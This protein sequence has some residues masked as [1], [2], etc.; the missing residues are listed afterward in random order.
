MM[1]DSILPS[2]LPHFSLDGSTLGLRS[3]LHRPSRCGGKENK[4]ERSN[5][6]ADPVW[7]YGSYRVV[8][9]KMI[10]LCSGK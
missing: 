3:G 1:L 6:Y 5:A 8:R 2:F 4:E 7:H 10:F 9:E